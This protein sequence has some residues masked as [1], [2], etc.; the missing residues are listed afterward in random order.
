MSLT[1]TVKEILSKLA[2]FGA[3]L[4]EHLVF[5]MRRSFLPISTPGTFHRKQ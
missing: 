1:R 2:W 4:L 5:H 3:G